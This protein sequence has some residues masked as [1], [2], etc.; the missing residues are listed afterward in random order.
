[1][2]CDDQKRCDRA[3]DWRGLHCAATIIVGNARA[4]GGKHRDRGAGVA[5]VARRFAAGIVI[6]FASAAQ[7][8]RPFHRTMDT[9][10]A[11]ETAHA[12]PD[13]VIVPVHC[14]GWQQ[15]A[16]ME[17]SEIRDQASNAKTWMAP[18]LGPARVAHII[19][20][21][22]RVN[23]DCPALRQVKRPKPSNFAPGSS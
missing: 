10:D 14:E 7:T 6:L 18:Q 8:R 5:E 20:A 19:S 2:T 13:A 15:V 21:A 22:S 1:M 11:I 3:A 16:R 23:W 9:N 4:L 12:F 17:R